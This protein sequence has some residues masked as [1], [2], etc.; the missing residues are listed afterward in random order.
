MSAGS[1]LVIAPSVSGFREI[2]CCL[3][4]EGIRSIH[5]ANLLEALLRQ[6]WERTLEGLPQISTEPVVI[7]DTDAPEPWRVALA[8]LLRLRPRSRVVFL[9]RLADDNLWIEVLDTGGYDLI[10][11]PF[12]PAEIRSVVRSA[13]DRSTRIAAA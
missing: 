2:E 7:Y 3:A 4:C 9:S 11:K 13:L 1:V 12:Q 5:A 10:L 8:N 6:A